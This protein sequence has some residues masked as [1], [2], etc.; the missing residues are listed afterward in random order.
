MDTYFEEN[1]YAIAPYLV[2]S[3][4]VEAR[5]MLEQLPTT[6]KLSLKTLAHEVAVDKANSCLLECENAV[7]LLSC[8]GDPIAI[9]LVEN[10]MIAARKIA[11][12]VRRSYSKLFKLSEYPTNLDV[13]IHDYHNNKEA[14][15][16]RKEFISY[17][18]DFKDMNKNGFYEF[19][20]QTDGSLSQAR[21]L[22]Y[23]LVG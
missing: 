10:E 23:A 8:S 3:S 15:D 11:K 16:K 21:I 5:Q 19:T 1:L 2:N 6:T 9:R 22:R 13:L 18:N 7:S 14:F 12:I 4:K 20:K 17:I